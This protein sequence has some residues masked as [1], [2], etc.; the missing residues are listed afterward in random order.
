VSPKTKAQLAREHLERALPAVPDADYTEAVTWLFAALEAAIVAVADRHGIDTQQ[1]HWKKA[2]V[3]KQLYEAGV[4]S[5]DFSDSLDT[6]NEA[7]KVVVYEGDEPDL[8]DQSLEDIAAAVETAVE[9]AEEEG[10]P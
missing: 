6:L 10:S 7:R 5:H 1:Q 2:E 9:F 4:L 8:G 3:A